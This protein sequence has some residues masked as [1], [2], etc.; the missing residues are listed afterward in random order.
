MYE[1]VLFVCLSL[2]P[3]WCH[4]PAVSAS[5][6]AGQEKHL[7]EFEATLG[8]IKRFWLNQ[9]PKQKQTN[10]NDSK[11]QPSVMPHA[12]LPVLGVGDKG[13]KTSLS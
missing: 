9:N 3:F 8:A 13:L 1:G 2:N 11:I 6:E 5:W 7:R 12:H 4:T 10:S